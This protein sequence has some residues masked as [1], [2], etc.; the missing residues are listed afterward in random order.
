MY[1]VIYD[2]GTSNATGKYHKQWGQVVPCNQHPIT[3]TP[4][5]SRTLDCNLG[6]VHGQQHT[7]AE[8]HWGACVPGTALSLCPHFAWYYILWCGSAY[9]QS[10]QFHFPPQFNL[11][12]KNC[13]VSTFETHQNMSSQGVA[14]HLKLCRQGLCLGA[15]RGSF[16]ESACT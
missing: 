16:Q 7:N 10:Q 12:L 6:L 14:A 5:S 2:P 15:D 11:K 8:G 9:Q 4:F 3:P 1:Q 13:R